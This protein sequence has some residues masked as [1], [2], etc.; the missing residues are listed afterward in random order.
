[1]RVSI[2]RVA[3]G[4]FQHGRVMD[5]EDSGIGVAVDM[6]LAV[7]GLALSDGFYTIAGDVHSLKAGIQFLLEGGSD[8]GP[9]LAAKIVA[10]EFVG[11][12]HPEEGV[13]QSNIDVLADALDYSK[14]VMMVFIQ[15]GMRR[16]SLRKVSWSGYLSM[17]F[18][19]ADISS[20]PMFSAP[21]AFMACMIRAARRVL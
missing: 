6:D 10:L 11:P 2:G 21:V 1:M 13:I 7:F 18:L 16:T 14:G 9:G 5:Q 12:L 3:F 17:A 19:R 20:G 4:I 8:V 15:I